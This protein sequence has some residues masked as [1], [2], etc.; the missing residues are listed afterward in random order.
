MTEVPAYL[1]STQPYACIGMVVTEWQDGSESRGTCTLVGRNDIL[2]A[3]HVIYDPTRGGWGKSFS[4]YFGADYNARTGVFDILGVQPNVSQW[5]A[6]AWPEQTFANGNHDTMV[7]D[8]SEFDV[9]LIGIDVPLGDT[10]GW[11]GLDPGQNRTLGVQAVGYPAGSTGMMEEYVM[12][13]PSASAGAYV[14]SYSVMGPGSSGGPL[15]DGNYVIGVKSTGM[16]WAD[17]GNSFIYSELLKNMTSNDA[18]LGASAVD[19][20]APQAVSFSPALGG[21]GVAR[22]DNIVVQFDESIA[23]G[24]GT[25][26]LRGPGGAVIETWAPNSSRVSV[27]DRSLVIDPSRP[28]DVFTRYS[29][30]I[31][32]GFVEDASGNRFAGL[33]YGFQTQGL[34]SL[35]HFFLVAFDAAPGVEYMEQMALAYNHG[36]DVRQIVNVFTTKSQ[37]TSVYPTWLSNEQLS[38]KLVASVVGSSA[39]TAARAQAVRDID[40]ALDKGWSRGDVVYQVFGNLAA[41]PLTDAAW[42]NTARQFQNQAAV[43]RYF[44]EEMQYQSTDLGLLRA[45]VSGVDHLS[46]TSTPQSI[47]HL[48]GVALDAYLPD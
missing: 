39:S 30:D 5:R 33:S 43:A 4:F 25:V 3:G 29:I 47:A 22:G 35:Y 21:T 13:S 11:M 44:T 36:A 24:A 17:I 45:V 27:V 19:N 46:D 12:V 20:R 15:L 9:A 26:V 23:L 31:G 32:A 7:L 1:L 2:T 38:D 6:L 41:K 34:E 10:L 14:S 40:E 16:W 48:I 37:F 28:L 18:L 8:E 42:G